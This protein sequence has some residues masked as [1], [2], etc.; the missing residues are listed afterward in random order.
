MQ[1]NVKKICIIGAGN[2]GSRH[3]QALAKV[4]HPLLIYVIDPSVNSLKLAKSRYEEVRT[5]KIKHD[6]KY[7]QNLGSI[8]PSIDIAIIATNSNIRSQVTKQLLDRASVRYIIFE[9]I[10]FDK[11]E[12]YQEMINLLSEKGSK[13]WVNCSRRIMPFYRNLKDLLEKQMVQF[14]VSG[15]KWGLVSNAIHFID[16]MAFLTDCYD[17]EVNTRYIDPVPI[18]S[19]R[20]DFSELTG[21]L[22][23]TFGNGSL[24]IFTCY[25][26][27]TT[28]QIMEILSKEFRCL[29]LETKGKSYTSTPLSNW[30][31]SIDQTPLLNQSEMTNQLV[32]S[33]IE[34]GSCNLTPFEL[35]AK[36]HLSLFKPLLKY[37]N[38]STNKKFNH[39]PFT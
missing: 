17:F 8:D 21:T 28:P 25:P 37:L 7:L 19:K 18:K 30:E 10:L 6:L 4:N 36:M 3:L 26:S 13:A 35:S 20:K 22:V 2:I 5:D 16:Y 27:G 12:Q 23:I 11:F 32:S 24:G 31:W 38:K 29:T 14:I 15:S 9:K 39:L 33:L 1:R 34:F